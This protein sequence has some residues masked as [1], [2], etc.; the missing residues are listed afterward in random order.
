MTKEE[1]LQKLELEDAFKDYTPMKEAVLGG[2]HSDSKVFQFV[3]ESAKPKFIIEVGSFVG[4]SAITMAEHLDRQKNPCAILCI[5]TWLGSLEYWRN[6]QSM[7][8]SGM[9]LSHGYPQWYFSFLTNIAVTKHADRVVPLP[10]PTL[11]AARL[12]K[13]KGIMADLIYIDASH[14]E[15]DVYEDMMAYWP[16]VNQGGALFG[17]DWQWESVARAVQRFCTERGLE[18]Q[19]DAV[20]WIIQKQ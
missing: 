14:D 8:D 20:N 17:D 15:K 11:I 5:D 13:E 6:K 19:H 4:F 12:L 10:L 2:W 16:L 7:Q 18:F 3:I 1:L 9:Q